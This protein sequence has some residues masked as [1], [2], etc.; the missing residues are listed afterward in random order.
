MYWRGDWSLLDFP[1]ELPH[2]NLVQTERTYELDIDGKKLTYHKTAETKS[3][4]LDWIDGGYTENEVALWLE[5]QVRTIHLVPD[6]LRSFLIKLLSYLTKARGLPLTGLV[7]SKYQLARAIREQIEVYRQ[8][9]ADKGF[10][11]A[12]FEDADE[13][14][15]RLDYSFQFLANNY[16]ARP[17][18]YE[19]RYKFTKHFYPVIDYMKQDGEEFKCAQ[20]LDMHEKVKYWVKNLVNRDGAAFR[21]PL[22]KGW[23]YPDFVAELVDGRLLVVEYKGKQLATNDDSRE[24]TIVGE[25]WAKKSNGQCLFLMAELKN[26]HGQDVFQQIDSLLA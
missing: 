22:A 13:L 19:G 23:F 6:Q 11:Y 7:R 9:A 18:F 5:Q 12:L 10:N 2:F 25:L 20:I 3:Y 21:L 4:N 14:D 8:Q 1:A 16:P 26:V 15:T 17:P 24:K